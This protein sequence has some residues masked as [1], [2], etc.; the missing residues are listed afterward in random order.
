MI[1]NYWDFWVGGLAIATVAFLITLFTG[2]F[3]GVTKGYAS[4]CSIISKHPFFHRKEMGGAFGFRTLFVV[5]IMLGGLLAAL[6][7]EGSWNPSFD[8]G[9]FDKLFGD[10]LAV[11]A[12]LLI[13]GGACW[14][15]GARM[16]DGCTSGN[17]IGG[18][19]KGSLA[20]LI[21]TCGFMISGISLTF[22]LNYLLGGL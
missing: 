15:Y 13:F 6:T 4:V 21:T 18:L 14:G 17:A 7:T 22:L 9:W 20:S 5:G 8:Y 19:S 10:N 3:I 16:A 12:L 2:Q 1:E 11:K